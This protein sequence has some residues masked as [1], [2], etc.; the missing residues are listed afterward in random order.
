M[1]FQIQG[2]CTWVNNLDRKITFDIC[3]VS[4]KSC[5]YPEFFLK[6]VTLWKISY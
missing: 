4:N 1:E 2:Q 6:I 5:H 3:E